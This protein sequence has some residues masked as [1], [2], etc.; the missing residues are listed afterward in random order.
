MT[1]HLVVTG[2]QQ[3]YNFTG[4]LSGPPNTGGGGGGGGGG[5]ATP[6]DVAPVK[7]GLPENWSYGACYV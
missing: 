3:V 1:L 5:G 2:N 6:I 7:T 4:T